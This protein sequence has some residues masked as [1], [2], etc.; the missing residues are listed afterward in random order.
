MIGLASSPAARCAPFSRD[1]SPVAV[2][3]FLICYV[4]LT[5]PRVSV[6]PFWFRSLLYRLDGVHSLFSILGSASLASRSLSLLRHMGESPFFL[7]SLLCL[8]DLS[9]S[10]SPLYLVHLRVFSI[11]CL[12]WLSSHVYKLACTVRSGQYRLPLRS[13][14]KVRSLSLQLRHLRIYAFVPELSPSATKC[15]ASAPA[16][17]EYGVLRVSCEFT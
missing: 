12:Y 16:I 6:C 2:S 10:S 15:L 1:G 11:L 17:H 14:L 13:Q 5:V 3:Y 9:E 4:A 7:F 8:R